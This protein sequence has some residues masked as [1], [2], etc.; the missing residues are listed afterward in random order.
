MV[1]Q[2]VEFNTETANP[3]YGMSNTLSIFQNGSKGGGGSRGILEK[4]W[5][6]CGDDV[7]KQALLAC[8]LFSI[9]DVASRQH[10]LFEGKVESGGNSERAL[11]R[12]E[13]IPFL[14]E[15]ISGKRKATKL[16]LMHLITEYTVMDNIFATRVVTK[17]GSSVVL[18]TIDMIEVF[19]E[20][21]VATYAANII[22]KGS[23][24]QKMS[25]AKYL[26]RPRLSK[27]KGHSK[28]LPETKELMLKRQ[29]LI[30]KVSDLVKFPYED[31]GS[32]I[33]FTGYYE[34]RKQFNQSL[35][36]YLFSSGAIKDL[37]KDTFLEMLDKM[38]SDAR[39]R[40]RNRVLFNEK[41]SGLKEWYQTWEKYKEQKQTEQRELEDKVAEGTADEIDLA[42]LKTVKKEAKV[43]TGAVNFAKLF[44]QMVLGTVENVKVQPILDKINLPYNTLLFIDDSGSMSSMWGN[45]YGFTARQF[46]AFMATICLSKNPDPEARNLVGLFSYTCRMFTGSSDRNIA[47]NS[48]VHGRPGSH[49]KTALIDPMRHFVQNLRFFK[50]FLDHQSQGRATY[51][52]SIPQYLAQWIQH[53]G[54]E[55][56]EQIRKFPVWTL[57]SDGN[58]N[59]LGG[60]SLSLND[61]LRKCENLLGFRP[62][63]ILIDVA[64]N[65]S[66]D[67]KTFSG[68]DGV[69]MVP[70]NPAA[71]EMFLM[72]FKDM[73]VYDVYTPLQSI[74]RS[75]R[76]API[77]DH[78]KTLV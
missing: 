28:L 68:I 52:S 69:M 17:K 31:K 11:F 34:W 19:G 18:D 74:A 60:A 44:N 48:L 15:K 24:F 14:V 2:K 58:F 47:V 40:T 39:F 75:K 12:K 22:R 70:P 16:R 41:W 37:D 20:G 62:F 21:N 25:L 45:K 8:V 67:I 10:N 29:S 71:I 78:V 9:G 26:T 57:I 36:S 43:N 73:D 4:A 64:G 53:G 55:A 5:N 66:Q 77:R 63:L 27:R 23:V 33:N 50:Q 56:L 61:F 35:E 42:K 38:P 49:G 3:Y 13:I 72:N 30:K 46:A 7:E 54:D 65:T 6:E 76:Y 32:Y 51:I 1:T 59:N